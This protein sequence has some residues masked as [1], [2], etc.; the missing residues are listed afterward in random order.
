MD[1]RSPALDRRRFLKT[2][3][4]LAL[5]AGM[6]GRSSIGSEVGVDAGLF[7]T[8]NDTIQ[9]ARRA[10]LAILKPSASEL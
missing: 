6:G 5:A 7:A 4:A 10:A 3:A 9:E 2:S 1:L 8:D